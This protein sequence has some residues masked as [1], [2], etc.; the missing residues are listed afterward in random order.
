MVKSVDLEY[1]RFIVVAV[2]ALRKADQVAQDL[3]RQIVSGGLD[4]GSILPREAE[5][6]EQYGV[7]RS[8]VRE[9]IKL[10]E[11]HRLVRPV[12][13]RGTEVLD[14]VAS[15]SPAVLHAMLIPEEGRV[16]ALVL[17][18][19]LEIRTQLDV[20][21]ST[22]AARHRTA[23]D[24]A[25]MKGVYEALTGALAD[26]A[27]YAALMDDMA[28]LIARAAKNRLF[29]MLVHW[30]RDVRISLES[31]FATVRVATEPHLQAVEG[32]LDAIERRDEA[33]VAEFVRLFHQWST[34]RLLAAAALQSGEPLAV[35]RKA[36]R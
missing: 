7:N 28:E 32:L 17:A 31:L 18:D 25:A 36:I 12:R 6:A 30:H 13:R 22:M 19:L 10:L 21:M 15:L 11:V 29:L 27:R 20:Q 23:G 4:V 34:P 33:T 1:I 2:K 3:L 9:A 35:V 14:P 5:L 24:L 8:V 16:D 26:P